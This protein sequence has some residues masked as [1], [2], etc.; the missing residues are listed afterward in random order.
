MCRSALLHRAPASSVQVVRKFRTSASA[1]LRN[2]RTG[3]AHEALR[4]GSMNVVIRSPTQGGF[5]MAE[6]VT[7]S[8]VR[9]FAV[10]KPTEFGPTIEPKWQVADKLVK[11]VRSAV[12]NDHLTP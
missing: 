11:E 12:D 4:L 7:P 8:L 1:C 10:M 2:L 9:Q 3:S 5:G 6:T